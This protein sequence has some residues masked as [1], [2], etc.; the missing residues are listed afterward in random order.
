MVSSELD[1]NICHVRRKKKKNT[2]NGKLEKNNFKKN[3]FQTH[4]INYDLL[5]STDEYQLIQYSK[6]FTRP[7]PS[8][9]LLH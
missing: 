2:N 4:V 9:T 8:L 5:Q 7:T 1:K 6:N 3:I